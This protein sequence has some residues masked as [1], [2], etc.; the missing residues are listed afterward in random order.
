MARL[1][2]LVRRVRPHLARPA[3][4]LAQAPWAE[5]TETKTL[6]HQQKVATVATVRRVVTDR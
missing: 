6:A 3:E 1:V 2:M 4:G 5:A